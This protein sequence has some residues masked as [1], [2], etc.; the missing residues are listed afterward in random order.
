MVN[1]R[2]TGIG[3]RL[4]SISVAPASA[5]INV[6]TT[7]QFTATGTYNDGSTRDITSTVAWTSSATGI[8]TIDSKGLGTGVAVGTSTISAVQTGVSG[9]ASLAVTSATSSVSVPTEF[10]VDTSVGTTGQLFVSW[11]AAPSATYYNVERSTQSSSGFTLVT[12]CS[13][14]GALKYIGTFQNLKACRDKGLVVGTTY[15]YRVQ[16]C[17]ATGCGNYT[18]VTSNVP[19]NSDCMPTQIPDLSGVK[20]VPQIK[21]TSSTVDPAVTFL[22]NNLE[23]A[24]Y[25]APGIVRKN[26][27]LVFLSGSGDACG[28]VGVLGQIGVNLGFDF[29]CVNYSNAVSALNICDDT[30]C[31]GNLFQA[32]LDATGPCSIANGPDCGTDPTTGQPYVN[33]NPADAISQRI[34]MMLQYLNNNGY[35]ANG[36]DWGSYLNGTAPDWPRIVLSGWSQGGSLATYTGYKLPVA[37]VINLSAPPLAI[38]VGGVMT[39]ADFFSVPPVT[40]IRNFYGFVDTRD[41]LYVVGRFQAVWKAAGFTAANNDGEVQLNTA[42]PVGLTCNAGVPSHNFSTSAPASRDG[43]HGDP[44]ELWNEDVLKY[45]LID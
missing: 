10:R 37:R 24:A 20:A 33:S 21:V 32:K 27:L 42:S 14:T 7:Q 13:G 35:N 41:Q 26:K 40:N 30:S 43:A 8:A 38:L 25:A 34:S 45:M 31:F 2:G 3:P 23:F 18:A 19:V 1:L 6:G 5:S 11:I 36:T 4:A 15:Y 44:N 17:N 22:P 29:M 28:G 12:Q 16:A 9:G 39:A